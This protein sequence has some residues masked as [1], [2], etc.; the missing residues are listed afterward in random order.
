MKGLGERSGSCGRE[1][2]WNGRFQAAGDA[3]GAENV[4]EGRLE[5]A[6]GRLFGKADGGKVEPCRGCVIRWAACEGDAE[7]TRILVAGKME[8]GD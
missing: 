2:R 4:C 6:P 5:I 3:E 8:A 1:G 7:G